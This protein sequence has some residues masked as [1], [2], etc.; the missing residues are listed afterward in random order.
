[1]NESTKVNKENFDKLAEI[2]KSG[3]IDGY[4]RHPKNEL[5]AFFKKAHIDASYSGKPDGLVDGYTHDAPIINT[6]KAMVFLMAIVE[7]Q[8]ATLE[9]REIT[10]KFLD[11]EDRLKE[12]F[13][14]H[15]IIN[16]TGLGAKVFAEDD[17]VY[18]VRGGIMRMSNQTT[19]GFE[20]LNE[21]YLVPA[22]RNEEDSS[23]TQ[24]VFL[25]PRNDDTLIVGSIIQPHNDQANLQENS[26]EVEIMFKRA[27]TFLPP[28]SNANKFPNYH[29]AQGLRPFSKKNAKVRAEITPKK[30]K[31]VH[32]YGHGGSGWT[33]AVGCA[34]T[35]VF[36]I[37]LLNGKSAEDANN[38]VYQKSH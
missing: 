4:R 19:R 17:D 14:P 21:A 38:V 3:R 22:Q 8:G 9:T 28:L 24:V 6:D 29:F 27:K 36:L 7:G 33:L 16:A 31:I 25:V 23:P 11:H 32:N 2:T 15:G 1:M 18:P 35:A 20:S 5:P 30:T 26:P 13:N 12:E 34:R 37:E 10:G